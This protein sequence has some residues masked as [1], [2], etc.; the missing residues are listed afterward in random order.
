MMN[1]VDFLAWV[2]G[3]MF[4]IALIIFIFGVTVRLL[5]M[6]LIGRKPDYSESRESAFAGGMRTI[7]RRFM[8]ADT[9]TLQRST[10]VIFAGY[11]FHI[12]FFIVLL[13]FV[14]HILLI[15][16]T[17]G[18]QW[19]GLP[20]P[21]I[22]A[23]TVMTLLALLVLLI[24][25]LV[26]PVL[27]FLS[28]FQDYLIWLLTF[29]PVLTGYMAFHHFIQPYQLVLALH[30]LSVELLMIVFPFTKLMHTFTLFF[31]RWYNGAVVGRKGVKT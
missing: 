5:E 7:F 26:N 17:L 4:S 2:R 8:P 10:I 23:A 11:V 22:D 24:N 6:L 19:A 15:K 27:R 1:A 16:D 3:P 12:G 18:I 14:P 31:A 13:L 29:L 25:R 30:I 28:T 20:T 9:G 21:I